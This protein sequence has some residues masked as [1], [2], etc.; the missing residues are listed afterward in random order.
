MYQREYIRSEVSVIL[1]RYEAEVQGR[2]AP[3]LW[4]SSGWAAFLERCGIA[5]ELVVLKQDDQ[6]LGWALQTLRHFKGCFEYGSILRGP[7]AL[8]AESAVSV[9]NSVNRRG[10]IHTLVDLAQFEMMLTPLLLKNG[11]YLIPAESG[12]IPAHSSTLDLSL[13]A[14]EI[15]AKMKKKCRYNIRMAQKS[16]VQVLH[17]NEYLDHFYS[18][19]KMTAERQQIPLLDI[20]HFKEMFSLYDT[21]LFVALSDGK[22][23]AA[24]ILV[25]YGNQS[26]YYY[27][28][29]D[30]R[31]Q[32][33][34]PS[35]LLQWEM[36]QYAIQRGSLCYD[37]MGIAPHGHPKHYLASVTDFK[38]RFGG[39]SIEF[40]APFFLLSSR[41][42][43]VEK[44]FFY[45]LKFGKALKWRLSGYRKRSVS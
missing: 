21:Q 39:D 20:N 13:S 18:L 37:F 16:G 27:G 4:Q 33:M 25:T 19:M 17:G 43:T 40:E 34:M 28:A 22:P 23:A 31:Y 42:F 1:S 14:D 7:A 9:L 3:S 10:R 11:A 24:A 38:N 36:I 8:N 29:M 30:I 2:F 26:Y 45:L 6:V 44:L 32:V 35:Y 5:H 15:F 41:K 12:Q